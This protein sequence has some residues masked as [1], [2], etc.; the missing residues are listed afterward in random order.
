MFMDSVSQNREDILSGPK[1]FI[2][3]SSTKERSCLLGDGSIL[4]VA[5][6]SPSVMQC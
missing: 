4:V 3:S 2:A 1:S 5:E 6:Q